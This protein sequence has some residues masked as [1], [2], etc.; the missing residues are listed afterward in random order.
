MLLEKRSN[1]FNNCIDKH[2]YVA[3][4]FRIH[5]HLF[6]YP[7]LIKNTPV[8]KIEI[9]GDDVIFTI[10]NGGIRIKVGCDQQD[11]YSLPLSF[12]NVSTYESDES[13]IIL[14]LIKPYDVVF[15]IGANIGWY[16][17]NILLKHKETS[18]YS[19]E[20]IEQSYKYLVSNLKLNKLNTGQA[21]NIGLSDE[22]KIVKFYYDIRCSPASS[23]ADLRQDKDTI[24]VECEVR[25]LDDFVSSLPSLERLDFIKCD[26][27]GTEY[28]V[29]KGAIETIK[30]YK[31]IIFS[32]MLRKWAKKF[33]YHPN[34]I[35][36]FFLTL[37]YECYVINKKNKIEKFGI[38]DDDTI[39]TNYLFFH[40]EKH[41]NTIESYL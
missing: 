27:E 22:N 21:Y 18:V 1:Y 2:Q 3:D 38:V 20:P 33:H 13:N 15:D 12:L 28:F 40:K 7:A 41:K 9:T 36:K 14:G 23:M 34:D 11:A 37:D 16:T 29:F 10:V 25:K 5:K 4:M 30:K 24:A 8:D 35:I 26:V 17:L 32:E 19:F 31:P 39:Q 6:A